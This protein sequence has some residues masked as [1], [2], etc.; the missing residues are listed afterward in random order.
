MRHYQYITSN[1]QKGAA[2]L[3]TSVILLIAITLVTFL[4]ARTVLQETKMTA[5]NYRAAQA[6][7]NA[8][9]AMEFALTYYNDIGLDADSDGDINFDDDGNDGVN[10]IVSMINSTIEFNNVI[11]NRCESVGD[12]KSALITVTGTSDDGI[13]R[14]TISQ[15]VGN[16]NI[17]SGEGPQQPLIARGAIGLTGN[18]KVVNRVN[19]ITVWTGGNANIGNST[20]AAT[21]IWDHTQIRPDPTEI[22]N[23]ATFE[24]VS[25]PIANVDI[26][27]TEDMGLGVD[28]IDNDAT[29]ANLTGDELFEGFFPLGK[30]R[31]KALAI[32]AEQALVVSEGDALSDLD[33]KDGIIWIDG[34]PS[35]NYDVSLN[36]GIYGSLESPVVLIVNGNFN[37]SGNPEIYGVLYIVGQMDTTGTVKVIGSSI[38][39][40]DPAMVPAGEAP[41]VGTGGVDLTYSPFT[42]GLSPRGIKGT[43][44]IIS[45]SWR[46]W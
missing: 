20:S 45:G 7:A 43:A 44:S 2:T 41:V 26:V 21:Y 42:Q 12:L 46:D 27:S 1:R 6:I 11:G 13:A 22:T 16:I 39:E 35:D 40:G 15:C 19:N 4:T 10:N 28:I 31:M 33:G 36:G 38:V 14:R 24:D 37:A 30:D 23:R 34:D 5:N 9:A 32:T 3:F 17:F 8:D 25:N 18:F 29:L